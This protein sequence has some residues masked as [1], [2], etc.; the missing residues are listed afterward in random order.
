MHLHL[1]STIKIKDFKRSISICSLVINPMEK[2]KFSIKTSFLNPRVLV[3]HYLLIRVL[4]SRN[5]NLNFVIK[6]DIVSLWLITG[7][8]Q[9]NWVDDIGE[10]IESSINN[11]Y[12]SSLGKMKNHI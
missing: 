1:H 11:I 9:T 7:K 10:A 6:D 8:F 5:I 4:L 12:Y 2:I 3:I